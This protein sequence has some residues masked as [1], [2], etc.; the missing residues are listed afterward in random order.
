MS[1]GPRSR[2][3]TAEPEAITSRESRVTVASGSTL[4]RR[5]KY[6]TSVKHEKTVAGDA[7]KARLTTTAVTCR[8]AFSGSSV[9][10]PRWSHRAVTVRD[11]NSTVSF[12]HEGFAGED[13]AGPD[14]GKG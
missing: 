10:L 14:G 6:S 9:S 12:H 13:H 8:S 11:G 2:D 4:R 3:A 7:S 1:S 5:A